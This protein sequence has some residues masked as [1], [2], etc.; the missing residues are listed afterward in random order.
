MT[1]K[2][3]KKET[4]EA[5]RVLETSGAMDADKGIVP[6]NNTEIAGG[7]GRSTNQDEQRIAPPLAVHQPP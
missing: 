1:Q 4:D 3:R 6:K 2:I 5:I 7:S